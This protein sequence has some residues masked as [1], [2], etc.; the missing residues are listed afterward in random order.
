MI[1][2]LWNIVNH[3]NYKWLNKPSEVTLNFVNIIHTI[4]GI[5]P[6]CKSNNI[7]KSAWKLANK[8][9]DSKRGWSHLPSFRTKNKKWLQD[10]VVYDF[11]PHLLLEQVWFSKGWSTKVLWNKNPMEWFFT[12][13]MNPLYFIRY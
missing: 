9:R 10:N 7:Y 12:V 1:I 13:R 5:Q 8:V 2:T 4:T 6:E 3:T 11:Q